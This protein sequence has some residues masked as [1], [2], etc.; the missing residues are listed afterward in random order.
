MW[1]NGHYLVKFWKC[2]KAVS[3]LTHEAKTLLE[4]FSFQPIM[5]G[6]RQNNSSSVFVS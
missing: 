2:Q 5:F 1:Q 3:I 4:R 6:Q